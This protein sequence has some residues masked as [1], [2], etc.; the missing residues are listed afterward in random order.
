VK[1]LKNKKETGKTKKEQIILTAHGVP[2]LSQA[3]S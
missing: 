2:I 3:M 1:H